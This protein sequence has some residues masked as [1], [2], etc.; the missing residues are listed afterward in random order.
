MNWL[1]TNL[2]DFPTHPA[3]VVSGLTMILLF[4]LVVI[5]RLA[6]G[7]AFP[8]GYDTWIWALVAVAGVSTAGGIG[9]R[10]TDIGY[11]T[12]KNT[13]PPV[14]VAAPSTVTVQPNAPTTITPST[15]AD[16]P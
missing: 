14:N 7:M 4:G 12:A 8:D 10:L 2:Q 13:G 11:V 6:L 1:K 3:T 9:K 5:V 16:K 15:D